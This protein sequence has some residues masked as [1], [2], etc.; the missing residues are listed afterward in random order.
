MTTSVTF[1]S[2]VGGDGST[3]DDSNSPS[4]GLG[5]GGHRVRFV[6]AL[7]NVVAV[8]ANVVAKSAS[9]NASASA[10]AVSAASAA[11]TPA[12]NASSTT[13]LTVGTGSKSLTIETGKN[14]VLGM[15]VLLA[16]TASPANTMYGQV[17]SY[18]AGSG[19]LVVNVTQVTGSGTLAAWTVSLSGPALPTVINEL[20]GADIASSSTLNLDAA[21]GNFVHVTGTTPITAIT[22][23][24]GAERTV[25]FDGSL[26]ITHNSVSLPLPGAANITTAAGDTMLVRGDGAGNARV[27][28]YTRGSYLPG[29][30]VRSTRTAS[31]TLNIADNGS[32]VDITSGTFTQAFTAAASLRNG[33]NL[34]LR[35]SGTGDITIPS[36]DGVT[37]WIMYPGEARIFQCDGSVFTS[38]VLTPFSRKFTTS[39]TFVKPPGYAYFGGNIVAGGGSGSSVNSDYSAGGGGG[40]GFAFDVASSVL[41]ATE[42]V[43]IGSGGAGVSNAVGNTGGNTTLGTAVV[44]YGG[45]GGSTAGG[46]GGGAVDGPFGVGGTVGVVGG[47][48]VMGGGG[49]AG[50]GSGISNGFAG[51]KS[52]TGGGGGGSS[53]TGGSSVGA[54]GGTSKFAGAG[55]AGGTAGVAAAANGAIPGGGGGGM[56]SG[57][58]GAGGRGELTVWGV[59]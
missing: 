44:A 57:T 15:N 19:A 35:N 58:S 55:G 21:S 8:A 9:A 51:G 18:T 39:G 29:Q 14:F 34:T 54:A 38:I 25:V 1:S 2:A 11:M 16:S 53:G 23:A 26:T 59:V 42:T 5:N 48:S 37:N 49:G 46:D 36:S 41:G 6:S 17:T 50:K 47:N 3:V 30:M 22:L 12:T 40:Q 56:S 4:T 43:A 13:S 31:V 28:A 45:F 27:V 32:F 7:N 10:A 33:W 20:K 52:V 24:S